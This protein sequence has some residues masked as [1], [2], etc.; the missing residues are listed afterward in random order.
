MFSHRDTHDNPYTCRRVR[1][2][3]AQRLAKRLAPTMGWIEHHALTCPRCQQKLHGFGRLSLAL[4][5]IK[6]QPR[7]L[8]LL[9]RA[10]QQA[11]A[12]LARKTRELPRAQRLRLARPQPSAWNR[13]AQPARWAGH[14]AACITILILG[15]LG[16][17]S[18]MQNLQNEGRDTLHHLYA[19]NAGD[20]I[21]EE[22]FRA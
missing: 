6:S 12:H 18:S 2:R 9:A 14:A 4:T 8:D 20:D 3:L 10:N 5:L 7:P 11:I 1:D 17:L 19:Q 13:I 15:R 21:A 22:I 16:I